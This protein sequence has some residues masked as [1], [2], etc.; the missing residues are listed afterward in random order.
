MTPGRILFVGLILVAGLLYLLNP[1]PEAF[2]E[3]LQAE[4]AARAR[5]EAGASGSNVTDFL[6]DRLGRRAGRVDIEDVGRENY[7]VASVY[8]VDLNGRFPGGEW[9]YLGIAGWFT[10]IEQPSDDP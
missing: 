10:P 9:E 4:A 8:R 3:F 1:G 7:Y 2:Q 6:D 5:E